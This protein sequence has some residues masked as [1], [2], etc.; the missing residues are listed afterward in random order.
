MNKTQGIVITNKA[1]NHILAQLE[2]S[3]SSL[4]RLGIKES[5]CNGFMYTLDYLTEAGSSDLTLL[6]NSPLSVCT[7]EEDLPY[8]SGTEIDLVTEGLNSALV[9][10]N[11]K[12]QSYCGCGESFSFD[13]P[14]FKDDTDESDIDNLTKNVG[15]Q[16]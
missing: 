5:G 2:K 3:G 7:S 8:V 14:E 6:D 12:A 15:N 11:P 10:K 13:F 4:L 1:E 16:S 9:F